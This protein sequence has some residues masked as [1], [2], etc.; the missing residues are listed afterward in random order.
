L[1]RPFSSSPTQAS[2]RPAAVLIV[3][4]GDLHRG[5][6]AA[7][8]RRDQRTLNLRVWSLNFSTAVVTPTPVTVAGFAPFVVGLVTALLVP[9][10]AA[11]IAIGGGIAT[12]AG[13]LAYSTK[14]VVI[15][16]NQQHEWL[17]TPAYLHEFLDVE[18]Y[19]TEDAIGLDITNELAQ[20]LARLAAS[21]GGEGPVH[22][23]GNP[24]VVDGSSISAREPSHIRHR[25]VNRAAESSSKPYGAP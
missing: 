15:E 4:L 3:R 1:L 23:L 8:F 6:V 20:Y 14:R 10:A 5:I 19:T 9:P 21:P 12:S 24:S 25:G 17:P 16:H 18:H 22:R 11:L 7:C 13:V 2:E